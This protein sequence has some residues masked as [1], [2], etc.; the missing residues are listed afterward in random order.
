MCFN[1]LMLARRGYSKGKLKHIV[2][3]VFCLFVLLSLYIQICECDVKTVGN[4]KQPNRPNRPKC[5]WTLSMPSMTVC[6][7][8]ISPFC[9]ITRDGMGGGDSRNHVNFVYSIIL[10]SSGECSKF[11]WNLRC[12]VR[13]RALTSRRSIRVRLAEQSVRTGGISGLWLHHTLQKL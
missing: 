10:I 3:Y 5:P 6:N 2:L 13:W 11:M 1:K 12:V 7:L 4:K 8:N 9:T